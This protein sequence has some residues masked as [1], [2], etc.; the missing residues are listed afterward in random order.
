MEPP[1]CTGYQ[2]PFASLEVNAAGLTSGASPAER[3]N[4]PYNRGRCTRYSPGW[5]T[6]LFENIKEVSADQSLHAA[7]C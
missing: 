7:L 6:W 5:N 3:K 2:K 4:L 1:A